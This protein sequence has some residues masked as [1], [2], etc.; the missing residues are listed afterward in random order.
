MRKCFIL[1]FVAVVM[2][3][4]IGMRSK[5]ELSL[6]QRLLARKLVAVPAG[7]LLEARDGHQTMVLIVC[8][9]VPVTRPYLMSPEHSVLLS[10]APLAPGRGRTESC[11]RSRG[12]TPRHWVA[13]FDEI[14]PYT[15]QR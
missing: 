8:A 2:S 12:A 9:N 15:A 5:S 3:L 4:P 6:S 7:S 10:L 11:R 1:T 13:W 14:K